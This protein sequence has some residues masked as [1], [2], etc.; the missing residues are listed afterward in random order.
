MGMARKAPMGS[1]KA[2]DRFIVNNDGRWAQWHNG[3]RHLGDPMHLVGMRGLVHLAYSVGVPVDE[4]CARR[5][6]GAA[7]LGGAMPS[8]CA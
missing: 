8:P 3:T 7:G 5:H 4:A 1:W 6:G 2:K